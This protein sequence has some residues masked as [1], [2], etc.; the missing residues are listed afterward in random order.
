MINLNTCQAVP[1]SPQTPLQRQIPAQ[2]THMR[3]LV[4]QRACPAPMAQLQMAQ[5]ATQRAV[6]H[7]WR[8]ANVLFLGL[9]A[10]D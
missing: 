8:T 7:R 1:L 5:L 4:A 6:S 3:R 9:C 2:W 10:Q